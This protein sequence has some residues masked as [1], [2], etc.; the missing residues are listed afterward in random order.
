MLLAPAG[1]YKA[2]VSNGHEFTTKGDEPQNT[3]FVYTR[4]GLNK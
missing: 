2:G 4:A 1:Q 3:V